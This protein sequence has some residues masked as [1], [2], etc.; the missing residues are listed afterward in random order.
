M[1]NNPSLAVMDTKQEA[2]N[3]R[4]A[5]AVKAMWIRAG[6]I[7]RDY[8]AA[9][10]RRELRTKHPDMPEADLENLALGIMLKHSHRREKTRG[11]QER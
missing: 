7:L 3:V 10:R 1:E 8:F 2:G 5:E 11:G 9:I 4:L 6:E